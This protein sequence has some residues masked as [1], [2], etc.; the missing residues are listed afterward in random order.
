MKKIKTLTLLLI[1]STSLIFTSCQ[2]EPEKPKPQYYHIVQK[3]GG[4]TLINQQGYIEN[5][6]FYCKTQFKETSKNTLSF[7]DGVI[8]PLTEIEHMKVDTIEE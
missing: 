4:L 8:I 7:K 2:K 6:A 3:H 5:G 1:I